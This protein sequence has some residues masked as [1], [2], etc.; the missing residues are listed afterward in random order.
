MVAARAKS[1]LAYNQRGR[2]SVHASTVNKCWLWFT[3]HFRIYPGSEDASELLERDRLMF[4]AE[5]KVFRRTVLTKVGQ[6]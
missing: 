6:V 2:M 3:Y 1:A 5:L 4:V